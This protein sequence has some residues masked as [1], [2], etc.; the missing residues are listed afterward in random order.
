MKECR[1]LTALLVVS[2][3]FMAGCGGGGSGSPTGATITAPSAPTSVAAS[4]LGTDVTI[5]WK[6]VAGAA[7]Y[8]CYYS[9]TP[10]VTKSSTKGLNNGYS[11]LHCRSGSDGIIC[12]YPGT[13]YAAMTAVNSAGESLLSTPEVSAVITS[14]GGGTTTFVPINGQSVTTFSG[15]GSIGLVNGPPNTAQFGTLRGMTADAYYVYVADSSNNSIRAVAVADGTANTLA[16]NVNGYGGSTD[17]DGISAKFSNPSGVAVSGNNL[18]VA[19]TGNSTVRK[20]T[21]SLP[22]TVTTIAGSAGINGSTDGVGSS[23]RFKYP[24]GVAVSGNFL[25]V[26]DTGNNTIRKID[27]TSNTVTTIAG[28]AGAYAGF[29]EGAGSVARFS[30]PYGLTVDSAGANLYVADQDNG[31]IRKVALST[32]SVST[33]NS[34]V[35]KPT[36]VVMSGNKLIVSDSG[37]V[38]IGLYANT[39]SQIDITGG[40][41]DILAGGGDALF[42]SR[43]GIGT[44]ATFNHPEGIAIFGTTLYVSDTLS[45]VVRKIQ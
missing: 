4:V 1:W 28:N 20:I 25:Y 31:A 45:Q 43:D 2:L 35:S 42:V 39:V 3:M 18:Y 12:T 9:S 13:Y 19:D 29:A 22:Y 21:L 34:S 27:L 26:T 11:C 32:N 7:S 24:R 17:A 23:A 15:T 5:S 30:F 6:A 36:G 40:Q 14:S 41:A 38:G 8:H 10:G 33:L 37:T 44:N 16:G